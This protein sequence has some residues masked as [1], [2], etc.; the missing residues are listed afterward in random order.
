MIFCIRLNLLTVGT[1]IEDN[2]CGWLV[3]QAL[4]KATPAQRKII[5]DNYGQWDEEKVA[6]I[7]ALYNEMGLKQLFE[8]Y[9]EDSYEEIQAELKKVT[10]VP[11]E[12]FT[13]FLKKIYKRSK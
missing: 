4:K 9:E 1:D 5:E 6:N 2:K 11:Q 12:V 10:A 3:V 13:L 7:K 8:K